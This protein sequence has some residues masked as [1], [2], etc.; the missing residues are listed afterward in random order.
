MENRSRDRDLTNLERELEASFIADLDGGPDEVKTAVLGPESAPTVQMPGNFDVNATSRFKSPEYSDIADGEKV[1]VHS[2]SR[3]RG[4][5]GDSIDLDLDRRADALGRRDNAE[6]PRADDAG[7]SQEV[8]AVS[9][10]RRV[11]S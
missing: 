4:L 2:T 7:L 10:G 1:D 6:K 8:V 3:L 11:D 9:P 5:S